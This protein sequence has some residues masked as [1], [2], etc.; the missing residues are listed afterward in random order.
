MCIFCYFDFWFIWIWLIYFMFLRNFMI[1][2]LMWLW[3]TVGGDAAWCPFVNWASRILRCWI[4]YWTAN[5]SLHRPTRR[6][7]FNFLIIRIF[8]CVLINKEIF[9]V[10]ISQINIVDRSVHLVNCRQFGLLHFSHS[11]KPLF[12]LF[13][14]CNFQFRL[15]TFQFSLAQK[16][17]WFC[18]QFMRFERTNIMLLL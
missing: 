5:Q 6:I 7:V 12:P 18:G 2:F 13:V 11:R 14:R 8:K 9:K 17:I 16:L 10:R 15:N 4:L 1:N 3:S